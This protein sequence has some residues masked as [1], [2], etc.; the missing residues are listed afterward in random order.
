[1]DTIT[2]AKN[3]PGP[4]PIKKERGWPHLAHGVRNCAAGLRYVLY[5]FVTDLGDPWRVIAKP[6]GYL[7]A[8]RGEER[9]GDE[10]ESSG[11]QF[12]SAGIA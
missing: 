11:T 5:V 3:G 7:I 2:E 6:H 1:M 9:V 8:P 10:R 12:P 4:Q